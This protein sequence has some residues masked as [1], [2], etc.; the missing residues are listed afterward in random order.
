MV[1]VWSQNNSEIDI[2]CNVMS[3]FSMHVLLAIA[4]WA[5]LVLHFGVTL[6]GL[7]CSYKAAE[8]PKKWSSANSTGWEICRGSVQFVVRSAWLIDSGA[9]EW[10]RLGITGP[11][12]LSTND[13]SIGAPSFCLSSLHWTTQQPIWGIGWRGEEFSFISACHFLS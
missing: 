5:R 6:I 7:V 8:V 2:I 12:L 10:C 3:V 1:L 13:S 9:V 4:V 11:G